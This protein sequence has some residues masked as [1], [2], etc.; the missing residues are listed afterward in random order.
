MRKILAVAFVVG[1]MASAIEAAVPLASAIAGDDNV[2][3]VYDPAGTF[4]VSHPTDETGAAA[5]TTLEI[6]S[7]GDFFTGPKPAGLGGTFDVWT[8]KKAF[9]L[10]PAGFTSL[11]LGTVAAGL[12]GQQ[13]SDMLTV[14][15]SWAGGGALTG[16]NLYVVPEPA[17]IV[18]LGLGSLFLLRRRK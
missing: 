2:T 15:G 13:V 10:E 1:F 14:S 9:K 16:I 4:R 12:S 5:I 18:L 8:P 11:D 7:S 6:I 3:L 17:S